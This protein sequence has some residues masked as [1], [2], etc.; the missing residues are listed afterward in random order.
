MNLEHKTMLITGGTGGIGQETAL[1]LA[2]L[3]AR[4]IVT[5]RDRG[6]GEAAVAALKSASGN[7]HVELLLADLSS[8]AE[9]RRLADDVLQRFPRLDVLINNAGLLAPTR[10]LTVDGIEATLAVNHL[11]PFLLTHLLLP[12]LQAAA[13]TRVVNV[14]GGFPTPID[15][16]NLQAEQSFRGIDTYSRAKAVM[17]TVSYEFAQRLDG[18]GVTLNVA[19]PG[20][21]ATAMTQGMT[22]AM[23]PL[24]M[25][26]VWPLFGLVMGNAKPARAARSSIFL[27]A[28]PSVEGVSGQYFTTNS[29]RTTWPKQVMDAALRQRLWQISAEMAGLGEGHSGTRQAVTQSIPAPLG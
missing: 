16:A 25:R 2:K 21:A 15:L 24:G 4:V 10:R 8:Q 19:Y 23:V 27:A 14:T 5:G 7:P 29:K 12:T 1:G 13:P 28:S 6:R 11:A 20:A 26:L 22:P 3:G 17:M 9:V 18:G